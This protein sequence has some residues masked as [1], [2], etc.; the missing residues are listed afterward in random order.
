MDSL[1][2]YADILPGK[3]LGGI[4]V[5]KNITEY[6]ALLFQLDLVGA[7]HFSQTGIYSVRYGFSDFPIEINVDIRNGNIYKISA[8]NGYLGKFRHI[9]IGTEISVLLNANLKFYYDACDEAFYSRDI[10]GISIEAAED[11]PDFD[12][13]AKM[14]VKYISVYSLEQE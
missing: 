13:I 11:D 14:N 3:G 7:L 10:R 6:S 5:G 9:G 12:D 1:D 8:L 2:L 4:A